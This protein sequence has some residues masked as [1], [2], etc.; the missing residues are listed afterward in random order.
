MLKLYTLYLI[1]MYI[2]NLP[3]ILSSFFFL[4]PSYAGFQFVNYSSA[5]PWG[6]LTLTSSLLHF[7]KRPYHI[8]GNNNCVAWLY[9]ADVIILYICSLRSIIDSLHGGPIAIVIACIVISYNVLLFYG[10]QRFN[11]FVYDSYVDMSL[12]S[13]FSVHL[14]SAMGGVSVICL[15][16]LR[17]KNTLHID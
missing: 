17:E 8:Y 1:K 7:T 11:K 12:L 14:V 16:E 2:T 3:L 13:H 10:G 15:R 6:A 5:I 9:N 4:L